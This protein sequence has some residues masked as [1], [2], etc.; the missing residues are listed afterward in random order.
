MKAT[1]IT[2]DA[3]GK[4]RVAEY[5]TEEAHPGF[6]IHRTTYQLGGKKTSQPDIAVTAGK[7]KRTVEEQVELQ[8]NALVKEKKD[9]GYKELENPIDEYSVEDLNNLVGDV[10]TDASGIMKP[11]NAKQADK[12]TNKKIF[13]K[14]YHG[15]RKIDGVKC[16]IYMDDEGVLHAVSRGSTSYDSSLIEILENPTLIQMFNDNPGLIIDGEV[17]K[18]G[19]SLQ[20]INS[21]VRTQKN[22]I[23]MATLQYYWYDIVDVNASFSDRLDKMI[24]LAEQYGIGYDP[25][26]EFEDGELR[27]QLVPQIPITGWDN[28][29]ELHN[30]YVEEGWEGLVIKLDTGKYG[31]GKRT[32]DCI[33]I[34]MYQDA[35]FEIVGYELGLRGNEDMCFV[36]VTEDGIEF[37]AKPWGDRAQKDWYVENF[38][39]ECLGKMAVVKF[40]YM[41][42]ENVPLQPS[43]KC[44]RLKEDL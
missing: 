38:D 7:V 42:D 43:V 5:A 4:I 3:K 41:S 27:V 26:R 16:L 21:L 40:F 19:L 29:L 13:D 25:Y 23:D 34:K 28:M 17:Y 2:R 8:F 22:V 31:P 15:S 35:E 18:H 11:M 39:T 33:K 24:A 36:C 9:K 1:L 44:I 32:N 12:V 30:Q 37:K 10:K 20:Q 6:I 14:Q